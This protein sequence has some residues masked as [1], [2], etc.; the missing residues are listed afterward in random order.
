[1][2]CVQQQQ[3]QVENEGRRRT[4]GV[5][6]GGAREAGETSGAGG[7]EGVLREGVREEVQ[8][9]TD[10]MAKE[11]NG[12]GLV[13]R[14]RGRAVVYVVGDVPGPRLHGAQTMQAATCEGY[15]DRGKR[16]RVMLTRA[17]EIA[18][19]F[20]VGEVVMSRSGVGHGE[21]EQGQ[22]CAPQIHQ[23]VCTSGD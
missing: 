15:E 13:G 23:D 5:V 12:L 20:N 17:L 22:G 6:V 19:H 2:R 3:Q 21:R 7:E 4:G 11:R 8:D 16:E 14:G 1:M 18:Q 9:K 10:A